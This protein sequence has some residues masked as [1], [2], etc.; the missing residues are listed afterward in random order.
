MSKYLTSTSDCTTTN[1]DVLESPVQCT[2]T[3][4]FLF[5]TYLTEFITGTEGHGPSNKLLAF[6]NDF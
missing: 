4:S 2:T 6:Y 3:A 5:L 1:E